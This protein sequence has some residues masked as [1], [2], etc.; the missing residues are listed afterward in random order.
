MLRRSVSAFA[1]VA[2]TGVALAALALTGC[3]TGGVDAGP[4]GPGAGDQAGT[5][6]AAIGAAWLAGGSLIAVVTEGS[7]TC[8][9]FVEDAVLDE[10]VLVVSLTETT[11]E[12]QACTA[13][14]VKRGTVIGVPEGVEP[15]TGIDI[16]VTVD[17]VFG[18][19][20]LEGYAG[21]GSA[22]EYTTSAGWVD[23][24]T[25]ALLTWGSSSCAPVVESA[26]VES[27]TSV[28][29]SF[30]DPPADQVCTMDMA[31][32]VAVVSL[33]GEVDRDATISLSGGTGFGNGEVPID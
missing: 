13:D 9:P 21:G 20:R 31:P 26:T 22:D 30:V 14:L 2:F 25:L 24:R 33:D 15:G 3:A 4:G 18:E 17:G 29:V 11:G 23:D 5:E 7:S 1:G 10:G 12:D 6:G 27:P 28:A 32:R 19:T 16:Q 8:R